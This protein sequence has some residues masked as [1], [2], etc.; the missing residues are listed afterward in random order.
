M[1]VLYTQVHRILHVMYQTKRLQKQFFSQEVLYKR[2]QIF[3]TDILTVGRHIKIATK[4]YGS[5]FKGPLMTSLLRH[6][7][8]CI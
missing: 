5:Q 7:T 1:Y 3:Y 6:K 4:R 8:P 2:C